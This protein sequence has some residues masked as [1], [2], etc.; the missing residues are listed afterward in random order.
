MRGAAKEIRNG[1]LTLL[2]VMTAT[3]LLA[4]HAEETICRRVL[5][6]DAW[7]VK[8]TPAHLVA[9]A[10]DDSVDDGNDSSS[11]LREKHADNGIATRLQS[12]DIT[13]IPDPNLKT[14]ALYT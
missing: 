9:L 13:T 4:L 5:Y 10:A 14:I 2:L 3:I 12:N 7:A 8:A 1:F 6:H 11:S